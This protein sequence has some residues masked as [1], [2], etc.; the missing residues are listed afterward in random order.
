MALN[1]RP[2]RNHSFQKRRFKKALI[3]KHRSF[4]AIFCLISC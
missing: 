1:S 3:T 2:D 4:K